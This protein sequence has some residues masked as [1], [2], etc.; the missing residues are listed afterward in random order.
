MKRFAGCLLGLA[1]AF[2]VSTAAACPKEGQT[3]KKDGTTVKTVG[4]KAPCGASIAK[5]TAA[6]SGCGK[7]C[8]KPCC[9]D[10]SAKLTAGTSGCGKDCT[11]PCCAS[12]AKLTAKKGG[13]SKGASLTASGKGE[14]PIGKKVNAVLASL[15][16]ITYRVGDTVTGC[17]MSADAIAEKSGKKVEFLVGDEA[18]AGKGEAMVKLTALIEAK[19]DKMQSMQFVAGGKCHGCS[20]TAK[21]VAKAANGKVAYRV[22]GV[23]FD[24]KDQ[25]QL[26]LAS[27][28]EALSELTMSYEVDGK[29]YKCGQTAGAKCKKSGAKLTYVIGDEKT[30]CE[31]TAK[32]KL[33]EF[34]ARKIVETAVA[35]SFTL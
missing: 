20:V 13:C 22:G 27:I 1:L 34:R 10:K 17:S 31:T 16:T 29:T 35:K 21:S 6:K 15:P 33:A 11:K 3:V 30:G 5:L 4:D 19:V 25:A 12:Q 14:C 2:T 23:D 8:T 24:S 32:L 26:V 9:A 7:D 28:K 18:F